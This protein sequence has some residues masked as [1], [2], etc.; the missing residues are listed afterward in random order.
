MRWHLSGS[1]I[2]DEYDQSVV[3]LTS[4]LELVHDIS[5][6]VIHVLDNLGPILD[7][8]RLGELGVDFS[9]ETEVQEKWF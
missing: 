6:G 2:R 4:L 8:V 5:H 7:N 1:I 9:K 3:V